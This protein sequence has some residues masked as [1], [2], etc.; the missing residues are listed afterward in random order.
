M[1]SMSVY[2]QAQAHSYNYNQRQ[3][4]SIYAGAHLHQPV[5]QSYA[6]P[7][8]A[9]G[10]PP[11]M[12]PQP[13]YSVAAGAGA[14]KVLAERYKTKMCRNYIEMGMCPYETR[15]MFAHGEH[16]L[17]TTEMNLR[18]GLVTEDAIRHYKRIMQYKAMEQEAGIEQPPDY[19][20]TLS[21]QL[22]EEAQPCQAQMEGAEPCQCA[23]CLQALSLQRTES[24]NQIGRT[25]SSEGGS[26][27]YNPYNWTSS[28]EESH[29]TAADVPCQCPE[30]AYY[31]EQ[32]QAPAYGPYRTPGIAP[33]S[34][35]TYLRAQPAAD[36]YA[37]NPMAEYA[38]EAM[39]P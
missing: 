12:Q 32:H 8:Y 15:C 25:A 17:R 36:Y 5:P 22:L 28:V 19:E 16:E 4:Q 7:R 23:E 11:Q 9:Y 3:A 2:G 21:N 33:R 39:M 34:H 27:Q 6:G 14:H 24:V 37:R 26:F 31:P 29:C 20:Q 1:S 13:Q 38:G 10:Y 35:S 18:D 30:C